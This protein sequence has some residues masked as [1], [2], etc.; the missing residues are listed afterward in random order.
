MIS[1]A[2]RVAHLV[3]N[4]LCRLDVEK[5]ESCPQCDHVL[6]RR[7]DY[8]SMCELGGFGADAPVIMADTVKVEY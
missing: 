3:G 6:D 7:V 1:A 8:L 4:L 2:T 5:A